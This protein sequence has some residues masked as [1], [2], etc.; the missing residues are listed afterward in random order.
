MDENNKKDKPKRKW[1]KQDSQNVFILVVIL[2]MIITCIGSCCSC[3][4][5]SSSSGSKSGDAVKR[6][7]YKQEHGE[8]LT[9]EE[10]K[11]LEDYNKWLDD[12][13]EEEQD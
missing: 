5:D 10:K 11:A 13:L 12:Y 3:I 7:H 4:G 8:D 6:A 1:T 9:E 2:V